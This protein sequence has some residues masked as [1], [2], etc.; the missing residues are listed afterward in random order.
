MATAESIHVLIVEDEIAVRRS[1]RGKIARISGGRCTIEEAKNAEEA[2]ERM[3]TSVPDLIFLDMRMPGM[4]GMAFLEVL[5]SDYPSVKVIIVSGYSDFQ[6]VKKGLTCGAVDYLLKPIIREELQ[7]AFRAACDAIAKNRRERQMEWKRNTLLKQSVALLKQNLLNDLLA[8]SPAQ[9]AGILKKL[10]LLHIAFHYPRYLIASTFI[11]NY[12]EMEAYFLKDSSLLFFALENVMVES[13]GDPA[14]MVHFRSKYRENEW[15]SIIGFHEHEPIVESLTQGFR[16]FI[17]NATLYNKLRI[18]I[19]ISE[20]FPSIDDIHYYYK[21]TTSCWDEPDSGAD[22]RFLEAEP[23]RQ[24]LPVETREDERAAE[25]LTALLEKGDA[26]KVITFIHDYFAQV[27]RQAD[28]G[29]ALIAAAS[30][31]YD[32]LESF[33]GKYERRGQGTG[34]TLPTRSE[35]LL[36]YRT[37]HD[38]RLGLAKIAR[39][40]L[41]SLKREKNKY[42]GAKELV[43]DILEH[44]HRYYYDSEL[45]LEALSQMYFI[46]MSY[47]SEIFKQETGMTFKKYLTHIR[48]ERAKELLANNMKISDVAYL[49][50]FND[51]G[52]FSAVYK[53]HFG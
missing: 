28:S 25:Q 27:D 2:L 16:K 9:T 11:R 32:A 15:I 19:V 23:P 46:N 52:Y 36:T 53:K 17:R 41:A 7:K 3:K 48:M 18:G 10:E 4:G 6:Y 51:P 14:N 38:M 49:V 1:I 29:A 20:P 22:L 47:L 39:Q 21:K 34:Y 24:M 12:K 37:P 26:G 44:I 8:S 35:L 42:A 5:R 45:T 33:Y 13:L 43:A 31:I 40:L 30:F 50:G